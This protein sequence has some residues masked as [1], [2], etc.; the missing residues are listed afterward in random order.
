MVRVGSTWDGAA[1]V[2]RTELGGRVTTADVMAWAEGLSRVL[3]ALPPGT[4]FGLLYDL[5]G[6]AP[7]DAG[8]HKAMREVVPRALAGRGM[9][10]A[11]LDLFDPPPEV[12]VTA[13]DGVVCVAFANV[14]HD[15]G[16]MADYDRRVGRADQRFFADAA[17]AERWLA[18][19][20]RG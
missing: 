19:L 17:A 12:P 3:A 13:A 10:P 14:H 6:F 5:T 11:V 18:G 4:R 15:A 8:A 16:K 20:T 7:A 1:A 9:R 2:V